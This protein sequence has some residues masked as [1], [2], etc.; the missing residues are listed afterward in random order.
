MA[1][2]ALCGEQNMIPERLH[3]PWKRG[4]S[5]LDYPGPSPTNTA[6]GE[7]DMTG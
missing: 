1:H 3:L 5:C 4:S 6:G 7:C 2:L